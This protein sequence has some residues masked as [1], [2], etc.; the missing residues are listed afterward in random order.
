MPRIAS[1]LDVSYRTCRL[2][3]AVA[4]AAALVPAA[5]L[6]LAP[7]PSAAQDTP[8]HRSYINPFPNGDRYRVVVIGDSMAEGLWEGMFRAFEDDPTL[9]FIQQSK[10]WTGFVNID[11]YDWNAEIGQILKD[12]DYHIAVVMFGVG[13]GQPIRKDGKLLKVGTE[14]WRE[15][16]ARGWRHSSRS[17]VQP[18]LPLT[19]SACR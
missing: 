11:K 8:A 15:P 14:E 10:K 7:Q 12:G 19:G 1:V 3:R 13:E 6:A 4:V 17:C 9:D 18:I 16:M 5:M 2:V